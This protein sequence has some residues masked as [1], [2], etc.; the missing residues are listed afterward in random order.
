MQERE[1][2]KI[3]GIGKA[4]VGEIRLYRER[5]LRENAA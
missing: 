2:E 5:F 1:I 3:P 4:S